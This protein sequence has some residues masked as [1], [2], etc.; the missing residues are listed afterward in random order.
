[1]NNIDVG[2]EIIFSGNVK[3]MQNYELDKGLNVNGNLI[4]IGHLDKDLQL[5]DISLK[6]YD[7][8]LGLNNNCPLYTF[9]IT[10]EHINGFSVMSLQTKNENVIA[11]NNTGRGI[12]VTAEETKSSIN[13]FNDSSILHTERR[14]VG[15]TYSNGGNISIDVSNN[16]FF[17]YKGSVRNRNTDKYL[18]NVYE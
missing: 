2:G 7:K 14:D 1:M 15:I 3:L 17:N 12:T 11:Q 4:R 9:D 18:Q 16:I 10:S 6:A 8:R 5:Y 13:F